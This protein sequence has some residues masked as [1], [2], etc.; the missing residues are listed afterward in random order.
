[1]YD[2]NGN[3]LRLNMERNS[4]QFGRCDIFGAS[5][6]SARVGTV[7]VEAVTVG[8]HRLARPIIFRKTPCDPPAI[9]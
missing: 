3:F 7:P 4:V 2:F 5:L 1:M 6:D 8:A 9:P